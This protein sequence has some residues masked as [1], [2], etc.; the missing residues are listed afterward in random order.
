MSKRD[1]CNIPVS[2]RWGDHVRF[3]EI[4][5]WLRNNI[6][7]RDYEHGGT[8]PNDWTAVMIYFARSKDAMWFT[9]R[10]S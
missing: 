10:W 7:D 1:W 3:R 9:L 6:D 4:R 8:D 5:Q 2:Y